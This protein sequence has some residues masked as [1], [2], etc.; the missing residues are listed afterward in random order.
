MKRLGYV[1]ALDGIRG[2]SILLVV[3]FHYVDFPNGG[4]DTGVD[5]FFVLSGF[6]ITT[7]LLDEH[8]QT[9]GVRLR[10]FYLRRA[11]RL[12]PALAVLLAAYLAGAV[13][14]GGTDAALR[15]AAVGGLYTANLAQAIGR[16][17]SATSPSGRC[18]RSRRRSSSIWCGQSCSCFYSPMAPGGVGVPEF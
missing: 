6:L 15:A 12:L 8:A 5:L 9:G 4:G 2:L 13:I 11:R 14:Q 7:L 1:S 3:G 10:A 16:T 17:S 18:G